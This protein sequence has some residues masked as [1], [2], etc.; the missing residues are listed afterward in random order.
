M[1]PMLAD[2][3][4]PKRLERYIEDDDWWMQQK[5]DGDRILLHVSDGTVT[6]LNRSGEPRSK[7]IPNGMKQYFSNLSGEWFIDGEL[8]D[9]VFCVFD[10]PGVNDIVEASMPYDL[11]LDVLERFWPQLG[12][13]SDVLL[14][15]TARTADEKRDLSNRIKALNGEGLMLKR[16]DAP[17]KERRVST[18]LK[19]KFVKTAD[20]IVYAVG[21]DGKENAGLALLSPGEDAG[22][23]DVGR[24]SLL[25]KPAVNV[26]DV[27]EVKYL[28]ATDDNRL[29]QP[30]L[31]KVRTDK[32]ASE[33]T[34]DQLVHTDRT[35][36]IPT[37]I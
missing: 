1:K 11:R 23:I 34:V 19:A 35:L 18:M 7:S 24:C 31:M 33:C 32:H 37:I 15:P 26:G 3:I 27:V 28:Y 4:D 20:C 29:Y 25:G 17:Y 12:P 22:I 8:V 16:H 2:S 13:S 30:R 10:L 36:V 21:L 14:I 5:L 9:G 6:P